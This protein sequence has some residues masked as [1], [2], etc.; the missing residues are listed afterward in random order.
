M[1][2]FFSSKLERVGNR[3]ERLRCASEQLEQRRSVERLN[4]GR[5]QCQRLIDRLP[6]NVE[7]RTFG[8]TEVAVVLVTLRIANLQAIGTGEVPSRSGYWD[9]CFPE[10]G[11][12]VTTASGRL[13][14]GRTG[15][16]AGNGQRIRLI[17]IGISQMRAADSETN[18]TARKVKHIAPDR[19]VLGHQN[20]FFN[21]VGRGDDL[22]N[23]AP[24]VLVDSERIKRSRRIG[25]EQKGPQSVVVHDSTERDDTLTFIITIAEFPFPGFELVPGI[26]GF[27]KVA[28]QTTGKHIVLGSD[29]QRAQT[30]FQ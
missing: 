25:I 17:E 3:R 1:N 6:A 10:R 26:G 20:R 23:H 16:L 12:R 28:L 9:S 15:R 4:I 8:L 24:L 18:R 29:F 14:V 2:L 11:P 21:V 19:E 7:L 5:T 30:G 22:V 13:S 27:A